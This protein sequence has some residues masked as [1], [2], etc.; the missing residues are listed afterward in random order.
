MVAQD[1]LAKLITVL[2]DKHGAEATL[3]ALA[4]QFGICGA[5]ATIC[6]AVSPAAF[7]GKYVF[8]SIAVCDSICKKHYV[9]GVL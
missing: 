5:A 9:E 7:V 1:K 6:G 4:S 8:R 3:E 2:L